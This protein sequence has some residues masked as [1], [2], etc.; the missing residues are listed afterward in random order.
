M[1]S[2]VSATAAAGGGSRILEWGARVRGVP[3][4]ERRGA[5]GPEGGVWKGGIPFSNDD[6]VWERGCAS[7]PENVLLSG[8][9]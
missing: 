5:A 7:S 4:A 3:G 9:K 1:L 8:S 2:F 6:G